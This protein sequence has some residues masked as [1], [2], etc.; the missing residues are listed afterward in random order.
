MPM[1]ISSSDL[2]IHT[3]IR[4]N[5]PHSSTMMLNALTNINIGTEESNCSLL[6]PG[7]KLPSRRSTEE[8]SSKG[9][10]INY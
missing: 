9:V 7:H 5:V 1:V 10:R 8:F 2:R 4:L 3:E 6:P